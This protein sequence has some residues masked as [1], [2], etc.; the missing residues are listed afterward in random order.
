MPRFDYTSPGAEAGEALRQALLEK[1]QLERQQMLDNLRVED[2]QR[3]WHTADAAHKR[4][5]A[6]LRLQRGHFGLGKDA[7]A[8][9]AARNDE[10]TF[11]LKLEPFIG[12]ED[13]SQMPEDLRAEVEKRG[14]FEDIPETPPTMQRQLAADVL[15]QKDTPQFR[16]APVPGTGSPAKRVYRGTPEYRKQQ[17]ER[18]AAAAAAKDPRF[19]KDPTMQKFFAVKGAGIDVQLPGSA[20]EP[21][22]KLHIIPPGGDRSMQGMAI[23]PNDQFMQQPYAPQPNAANSTQTLGMMDDPSD[24]TGVK[25]LIV[26]MTPQGQVEY[27]PV[28]GN[29]DKIDGEQNDDKSNDDLSRAGKDLRTAFGRAGTPNSRQIAISNVW[30]AG[31]RMAKNPRT[32]PFTRKV[33]LALQTRKQA[34]QPVEDIDTFVRE[35]AFDINNN[36]VQIDPHE[37]IVIRRILTQLQSVGQ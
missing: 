10:E 19:A 3:G 11:R 20:L 27:V 15:S 7:D 18:Q 31:E 32:I 14:W 5:G 8:R 4:A 29:I 26:R 2:T 35:H 16:M 1:A 9:A 25:K 24:P 13:I 12:G 34:G 22:G 36:P 17:Q 21:A 33:A 6:G 30:S 23:G 37:L 28:S